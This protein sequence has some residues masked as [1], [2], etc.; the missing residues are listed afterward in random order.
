MFIKLQ[1]GNVK[2]QM[3]KLKC[4]KRQ[5]NAVNGVFVK[6]QQKI[7]VMTLIKQWKS[8]N[9]L[10]LWVCDVEIEA[11]SCQYRSLNFDIKQC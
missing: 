7:Y 2:G 8:S 1:V 11:T 9:I 10:N 6:H 3:S 5:S 4:L